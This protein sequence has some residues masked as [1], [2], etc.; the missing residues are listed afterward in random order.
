LGS[1]R[2]YAVLILKVNEWNSFMDR[3]NFLIDSPFF[4]PYA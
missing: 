1:S 3:W 2:A 4:E